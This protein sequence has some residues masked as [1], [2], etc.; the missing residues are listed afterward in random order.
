MTPVSR[1]ARRSPSARNTLTIGALVALALSFAIAAPAAADDVALQR[2]RDQPER[3]ARLACYDAIPVPAKPSEPIAEN[4]WPVADFGRR[5]PGTS[6]AAIHSRGA[7]DFDGWRDN[8]RIQLTNGQVWQVAD[9]STAFMERGH[10]NVTVRRGTLRS[11][12][13]D[14]EDSNHSPRV[15]R[16]D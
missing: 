8:A 10:R 9:D 13:L 4:A 2:C 16:V 11:Y 7:D 12:Y 3:E 15:R 1:A 14:S 6:V 5:S